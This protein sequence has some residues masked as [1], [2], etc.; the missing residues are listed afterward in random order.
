MIGKSIAHY[1]VTE[2]L[3]GGGML[4]VTLSE[5]AVIARS[6]VPA[7]VPPVGILIPFSPQEAHSTTKSTVPTRLIQACRRRAACARL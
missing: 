2:K 4:R 6:Y 1:R 3:G 5:D 7:G